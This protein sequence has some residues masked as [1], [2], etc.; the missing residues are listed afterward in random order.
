ML[1]MTKM[2]LA[3]LYPLL[4]DLEFE[5]LWNG[6][7]CMTSD[8]VPRIGV[9]GKYGNIYFGLAYN[10]QGVNMSFMFGDVIA[11]IIS[12]RNHGW[13]KTSYFNFDDGLL[14]YIPPEPFRW[15]GSTLLMKYYK[16]QDKKMI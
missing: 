2:E 15:L 13:E 12:N 1:E 7:L 5:N 8:E 9:R 10:G 6:L 14:S 3:R 4:K 16:R 11:S